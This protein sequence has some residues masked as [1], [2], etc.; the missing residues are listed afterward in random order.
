MR[1]RSCTIVLVGAYTVHRRWINYEITKSWQEGM[2]LAGIRIH[3]LLDQ[4]SR[5]SHPGIN[6]FVGFTI[7]SPHGYQPMSRIVK[8]HEPRGFDSQ[9]CYRW[10]QDNLSDIVEEAIRIRGRYP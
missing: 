5:S 6:P 9:A 1:G 4:Q 7:Q 3:D 10:I 2:G 8:L